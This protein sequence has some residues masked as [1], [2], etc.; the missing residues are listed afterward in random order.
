[1]AAGLQRIGTWLLYLERPAEALGKFDEALAQQGLSS[2]SQQPQVAETLHWRAE[3]LRRLGRLSE[4][5]ADARKA[6]RLIEAKPHWRMLTGPARV[7]AFA[8]LAHILLNEG[9]TAD[10]IAEMRRYLQFV[11]DHYA[12]NALENVC[13]R[14]ILAWVL[15]EE[16]EPAA[17]VEAEAL[18][19]EGAAIWIRANGD[20]A[21]ASWLSGNNESMLG[22]ALTIQSRFTEAESLVRT[23][24]EDMTSAPRRSPSTAEVGFDFKRRA[25]ARIVR[26]Y[27]SWDAAEPEKGHDL[28][29]AEWRAKLEA[30]DRDRVAQ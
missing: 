9:K 11:R 20:N 13:A 14:Q 25:L 24:Y 1:V 10:A 6:V 28:E 17:A 2:P 27:E 30:F 23:G 19:R 29:A 3:A 12:D 16:A 26:L 18:L 22:Q 7:D 21:N 8:F 15:L 4:A 5:E